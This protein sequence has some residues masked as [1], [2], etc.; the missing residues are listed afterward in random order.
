MPIQGAK[1]ADASEDPYKGQ[2]SLTQRQARL[3]RNRDA[4]KQKQTVPEAKPSDDV[5]RRTG[6]K[7]GESESEKKKRLA[8]CVNVL[9]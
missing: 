6:L 4:M 5:F 9:K 3:K 2:E 8:R 7:F 1:W